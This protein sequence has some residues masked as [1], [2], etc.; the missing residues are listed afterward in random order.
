[1]QTGWGA[2]GQCNAS[3]APSTT[4]NT[5]HQSSAA[6]QQQ[7]VPYV[8]QTA[9]QIF[10]GPN[11]HGTCQRR[12]QPPPP[13]PPITTPRHKCT[14]LLTPRQRSHPFESPHVPH[15]SLFMD[16]GHVQPS[17][18]GYT[19]AITTPG[20]PRGNICICY[21]RQSC[22]EE[23][24]ASATHANLQETGGSSPFCFLKPLTSRK[25]HPTL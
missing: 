17:R 18:S 12:P 1:M 25:G 6:K 5:T 22:Q 7:I 4:L 3:C 23:T 16:S 2:I 13:P 8:Q 14:L 19:A 24:A 20:M 9:M 11:S 10:K 15:K 21:T